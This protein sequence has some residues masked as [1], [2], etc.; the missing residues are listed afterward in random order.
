MSHEAHEINF[1]SGVFLLFLDTCFLDFLE[2]FLGAF[3]TPLKIFDLLGTATV[4]V[5]YRLR[6]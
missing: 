4:L 6:A 3:W 1:F 5:P 2:A